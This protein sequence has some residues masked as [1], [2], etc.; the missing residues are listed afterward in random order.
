MIRPR[1]NKISGETAKVSVDEKPIK[2]TRPSGLRALIDSAVV[3][4]ELLVDSIISEPP[5]FNNAS[6]SETTLSAPR[7]YANSSLSF[8]IQV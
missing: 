6:T 5:S 7:L 3:L 1:F 4:Y 2:I 8:E